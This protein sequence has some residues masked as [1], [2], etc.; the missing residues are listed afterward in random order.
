MAPGILRTVSHGT[1]AGVIA[2]RGKG[3]L[4]F[5]YDVEAY[6]VEEGGRRG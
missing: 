6:I 1:L 5:F 3:R 4:W 2:Y